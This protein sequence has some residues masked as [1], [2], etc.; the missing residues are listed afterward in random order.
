MLAHP[1]QIPFLD[2]VT[3]TTSIGSGTEAKDVNDGESGDVQT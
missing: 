3:S 2:R 1:I